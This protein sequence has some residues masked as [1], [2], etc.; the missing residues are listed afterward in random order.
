MEFH[1]IIN[2]FGNYNYN[3]YIYESASWQMHFHG[4]FEL[5]YGMEGCTQVSLNNEK[6]TIKKGELLLIFPYTM[7]SM[8]GEDDSKVWVGVF[9][10]DF[11]ISFAQKNKFARF[12]KFE[13]DKTVEAFLKENLFYQ[14]KPEHY[15]LISCLYMVCG[16]YSKCKDIVNIHS[17]NDFIYRAIDY[18]SENL[19]KCIT[20]KDM[21]EDLGYEYHY[22]S[23]LFHK[24]F[25]MNF[26]SFMNIFRFE[27]ACNLLSDKTETI[28]SV[29]A[30]CG[31]GSI[32]N[33]NRVFKDI[34]GMTPGEYRKKYNK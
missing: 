7:H 23:S 30:K 21:A 13:C 28:T 16:E 5:I 22:F 4:N 1:Q 33:F 27:T 24:Y 8:I 20:L 29:S 31:F 18:I 2:S 14:G 3:A 25:C 26:K 12:V 34:G 11:I 9:S 15:M 19:S 10:K 32:R 17:D 6:C